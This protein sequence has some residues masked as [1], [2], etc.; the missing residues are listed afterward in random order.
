[1]ESRGGKKMKKN[2][3]VKNIIVKTAADV[4][5]PIALVFGF[6]IILHGH[7]SPGGGF[8]GG[9]LVG[10]AVILIYL[11]YG[12]E[13]T[14]KVLNMEFIRKNEA[15]GAIA[16]TFFGV[17]GLLYGFNFC[18]NVFF[19]VGNPGDL[20]SSGTILF[21][22]YSVGYKV[23][24]GVAFLILLMISLLQPDNNEDNH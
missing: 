20:I 24:T 22:N 12:Y 8:Q 7:L 18:R 19:K 10:G 15:V 4:F 5:S 3:K 13:K 21:M 14:R 11:G 6:Y 9:V 23:L 1:M 17:V 2:I 16:Y